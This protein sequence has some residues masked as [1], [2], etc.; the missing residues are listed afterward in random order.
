MSEVPPRPVAGVVGT[1]AMGLGI[2]RSLVREGFDT[3]T[4]DRAPDADARAAAAG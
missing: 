1:G 2:A 3:V 4:R